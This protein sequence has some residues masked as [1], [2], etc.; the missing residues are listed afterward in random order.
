MNKSKNILE[1]FKYANMYTTK[2][3]YDVRALEIRDAD[4]YNMVYHTPDRNAFF[5]VDDYKIFENSFSRKIRYWD[6]RGETILPRF[7]DDEIKTILDM[8]DI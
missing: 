1:T 5:E 2:N 7:D 6:E 8:Y 4:V 3:T